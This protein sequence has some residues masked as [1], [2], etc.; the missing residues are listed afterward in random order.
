MKLLALPSF[1]FWAHAQSQHVYNLYACR[2]S[3]HEYGPCILKLFMRALFRYY[4]NMNPV[5]KCSIHKKTLLKCQPCIN[6]LPKQSPPSWLAMNTA[7]CLQ[8]PVLVEDLVAPELVCC[9]PYLVMCQPE[10]YLDWDHSTKLSTNSNQDDYCIGNAQQ[11][12][13]L[14]WITVLLSMAFV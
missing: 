5:P 12:N 4:E 6:M 9:P 8:C 7:F 14:H 1:Q 13:C 2:F 11:I 3:L 10:A